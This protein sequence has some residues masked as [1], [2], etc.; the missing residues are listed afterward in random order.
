MLHTLCAKDKLDISKHYTSNEQGFS[1]IRPLLSIYVALMDEE[2]ICTLIAPLDCAQTDFRHAFLTGKYYQK[3]AFKIGIFGTLLLLLRDNVSFKG[4][5]LFSDIAKC[6]VGTSCRS[7]YHTSCLLSLN[8][9]P[10]VR[11]FTSWNLL[12]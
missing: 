11:C 7:V 5:E 2:H 12:Q 1:C 10:G 8:T 3:I 4:T 9:Y 6:T